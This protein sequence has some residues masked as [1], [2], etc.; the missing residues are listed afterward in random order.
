MICLRR[1][2]HWLDETHSCYIKP[3]FIVNWW[4]KIILFFSLLVI[5]KM[6]PHRNTSWHSGTSVYNLSPC[7]ISDTYKKPT[8]IPPIRTN[9]ILNACSK[10]E[11]DGSLMILRYGTVQWRK[12][13]SKQMSWFF[14]NKQHLLLLLQLLQFLQKCWNSFF[15]LDTRNCRLRPEFRWWIINSFYHERQIVY[16]NL[17]AD[18]CWTDYLAKICSNFPSLRPFAHGKRTVFVLRI[19]CFNRNEIKT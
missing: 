9:A 14:N 12:L 13:L 6:F 3:N 17:S 15:F 2:K 7:I 19:R 10:I 11:F 1:S 16:V 18:W 4:R 5:T 8:R